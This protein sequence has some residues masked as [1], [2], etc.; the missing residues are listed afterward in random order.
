MS[1]H[2]DQFTAMADRLGKIDPAEFAGAV[3]VVPPEGDPIS[4]LLTD[5]KP[6]AMQFWSGLQSRVE[7]A[8]AEALQAQQTPQQPGWG[9]R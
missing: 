9:R 8:A 7:L 5:P 2:A 6:N 3:V 1:D 4:F